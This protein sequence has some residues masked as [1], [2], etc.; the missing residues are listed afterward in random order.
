MRAL[1]TAVLVWSLHDLVPISM[2]IQNGLLVFLSDMSA[3]G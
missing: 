3:T 1:A 2:L